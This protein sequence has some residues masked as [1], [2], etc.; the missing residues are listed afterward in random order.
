MQDAGVSSCF[1]F[2]ITRLF[3]VNHLGAPD[4]LK[5]LLNFPVLVRFGSD[6]WIDCFKKRKM[7]AGPS[8]AHVRLVG[9]CH[10]CCILAPQ[11]CSHSV[12]RFDRNPQHRGPE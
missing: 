9:C 12:L 1:L 6:L 4:Y 3:V 8:W 10:R 5:K 11:N 2:S 7:R